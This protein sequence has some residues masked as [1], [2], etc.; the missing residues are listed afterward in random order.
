RA[1]ARAARAHAGADRGAARCGARGDW[2][3]QRDRAL[4]GAV[5]QNRTPWMRC[6]VGFDPATALEH[7]ACPVLA[8]FGAKDT[9]VRPDLN[10]APLEAAF[11][12]AGNTRVV[13]QFPASSRENRRL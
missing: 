2:R 1:C 8:I 5:G 13:V 10:R 6:F 3:R 4:P 12:K 9:Q 7:V 11:L